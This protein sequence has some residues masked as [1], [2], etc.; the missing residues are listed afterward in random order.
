MVAE[1]ETHAIL[2]STP[3]TL[4]AVYTLLLTGGDWLSEKNRVVIN[5]GKE[6]IDTQKGSAGIGYSKTVRKS[7]EI[8]ENDKIIIRKEGNTPAWGA[9]YNQYFAPVDQ[10]TKH[11]GDLS[12]EKKLF[13]EKVSDEGIQL[14]ALQEGET[15]RVGDKAVVRLTIRTKQEMTYVHLK[16]MR[17]GCFEPV[18]QISGTQYRDGVFY[19]FTYR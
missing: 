1:S 15:L 17:A 6:T 5:W 3:A 16:D 14:V 12:I 9:L 18:D 13:V 8:A 19:C 2:G 10:M 4:N 7:G 11:K